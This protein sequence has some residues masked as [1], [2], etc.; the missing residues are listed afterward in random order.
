M[1]CPTELNYPSSLVGVSRGLEDVA[2]PNVFEHVHALPN[3]V[4]GE[5]EVHRP[6]PVIEKLFPDS[7]RGGNGTQVRTCDLPYRMQFLGVGCLNVF[8]LFL[9]VVHW[10]R[11]VIAAV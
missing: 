9:Q 7:F 4:D 10:M 5:N 8:L 11:G 1:P 2:T 3:G 6:A